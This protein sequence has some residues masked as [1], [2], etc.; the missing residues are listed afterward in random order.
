MNVRFIAPDPRHRARPDLDTVLAQGTDQLAIACA[1]LTLGGVA[2]LKRHAARLRL[3]DSFVVV[4][5]DVP[6]SLDALNALHAVM[7]GNL[8]VHLGALTPVERGVGPGLMHSK[9]F[10]ARAGDECRLWTGSHNLTASA[11]QGVNREAALLL[12]GNR[13]EAVFADA[14][15]HLNRCRAEAILFD[16]LNPPPPLNPEQTL[17]IHAECHSALKGPPWFVHLRPDT[18]D[19]D[20][21][22]RPPAAVWLYIYPPGS[23]KNGGQRPPAIA[24]YS[25]T[26]TALNFTERHPKHRGISADWS[27]ADYVID[28]KNG[29]PN[30]TAPAPHA[31]TPS[32]GIFRVEAQEDPGTFWLTESPTPKLERAVGTR[33][34]SEVD[35]EFRGFFTKQSFIGEQLFHQEY[36]GIKNVVRVPRKEVGSMDTSDIQ[37]RMDAP[38]HAELFIDETMTA[39][40]KFAFVYRAKYRASP[41]P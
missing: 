21:A 25:G 16:P 4:A 34:V 10:Y 17:V 13:N 19:Y 26:L 9:V 8:Y 18:I 6:T 15:T 2:T 41:L 12:E 11:M 27:A 35:P 29:V 7:P 38:A 30:L 36:R 5:W 37:L 1:F 23:L 14:L 28:I 33:Y 39:D 20:K 22:M 24:A 40:D 32:Q 31:L 3:T